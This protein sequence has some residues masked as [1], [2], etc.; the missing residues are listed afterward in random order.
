MKEWI[1]GK[2]PVCEVLKAN[3]RQVFQL[4]VSQNAQE[5]GKLAE[6]IKVCQSKGISVNR[7]PRQVLDAIHQKNQGVA[8]QVNG[9]TYQTI[10]D[11]LSKAEKD[12]DMPLI[13]ILD[14]IQ[15][16]QNMATLLRTAE[17]VGVHGVILPFRKTVNI[18]PAVVNASSGACEH[19]VIAQQNIAQAIKQLKNEGIWVIG[20]AASDD[21]EKI[22]QF[23]L[24]RPLAIVIGSEGEGIRSLVLRSCDA[25]LK[26]PMRGKIESL[27]AAIAGS[28]ALYFA[29]QARGFQS[30]TP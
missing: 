2:N 26:I 21:A 27:N 11:I 15:D 13:L 10:F 17:I 23:E 18:T 6:I 24:C 14:E 29:W 20:L 3:R 28:V 5:K 8:I 16:P 22:N 4:M 19:L 12:S 25:V 9:Y 1:Y 7:V 30:S